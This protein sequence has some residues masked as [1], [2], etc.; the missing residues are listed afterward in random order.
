MTQMLDVRGM[1]RS[2]IL[3]LPAAIDIETAGRVLGIGRTSAYTL[4]KSGQFPC[5]VIRAGRKYR[6]PT[7]ALLEVLEIR[8]S[9]PE[10][11]AAA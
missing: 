7:A 10:G 11:A 9:E 2:E 6:V 3:A 8:V 5:R 1:T 4:A